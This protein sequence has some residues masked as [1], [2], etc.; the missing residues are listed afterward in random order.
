MSGTE[1]SAD[2]GVGDHSRSAG[3]YPLPNAERVLLWWQ[4]WES[5]L[6]PRPEADIAT[7]RAT[8]E[9]A[10]PSSSD[11]P[12]ATSKPPRARRLKPSRLAKW[13]A[14]WQAERDAEGER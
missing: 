9:A 14:H 2:T 6:T 10:Q 1:R 5:L 11:T 7:R 13:E 8:G 12:T 3:P 4:V